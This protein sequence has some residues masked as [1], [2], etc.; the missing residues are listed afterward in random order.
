MYLHSI[1]WADLRFNRTVTSSSCFIADNY[2]LQMIDQIIDI[3]SIIQTT[4]PQILVFE[5]DRPDVISLQTLSII[6]QQFFEIPLI[7]ITQY[8]SEALAIWALRSRINDYLISPIQPTEL[9]KSITRNN[10][11]HRTLY[12]ASLTI[13]IPNELSFQQNYRQRTALATSYIDMHYNQ[14]ITEAIVAKLCNMSI[15]NFSRIFKHE[16]QKTFREYIINYRIQK[17]CDLLKHTNA[18]ISNIAFQTGF[19]DV[20]YF[21]KLFKQIIGKT[22]TAFQQITQ[23][24]SISKKSAK[25]TKVLQNTPNTIPYQIPTV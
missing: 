7:M 18:N 2:T 5:F 4:H 23:Q 11:N 17:A 19:N 9:I 8:H 10:Q 20:S 22:P 25:T 1:L 24:P 12:H 6:H 16:Q 13:N 14:Q 15:S 3:P 21:S